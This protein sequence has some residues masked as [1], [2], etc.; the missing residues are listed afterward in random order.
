MEEVIV[1]EGI[2]A[3]VTPTLPGVLPKMG[4]EISSKADELK[5]LYEVKATH[6]KN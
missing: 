5:R 2:V 3:W 1:L 4:I 6:Y